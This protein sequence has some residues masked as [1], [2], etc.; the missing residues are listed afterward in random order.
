MSR[1]Y[2]L[3]NLKEALHYADLCWFKSENED[4]RDQYYYIIRSIR[5]IIED[6]EEA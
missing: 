3:D 2:M 4:E 5:G 1:K 6:M